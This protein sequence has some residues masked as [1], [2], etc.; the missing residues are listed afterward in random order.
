[1]RGPVCGPV[2]D[3]SFEQIRQV[4]FAGRPEREVA[5]ELAGSLRDHGHSQVDF[6][7]VG[8]GPN[9]ANPHHEFDERVIEKGDMVVLDFGGI[10]D[11]YGS[12]TT[13]FSRR[14]TDEDAR[15]TRSFA[16]HRDSTVRR[17]GAR[18][19]QCDARVTDRGLTMSATLATTCR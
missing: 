3:A 19:R 4:R 2:A 5:A 13:R 8:S 18:S 11:G 7:V 6:T 14:T 15:S 9:G 16:Q 17:A 10:K 12:D 1:M